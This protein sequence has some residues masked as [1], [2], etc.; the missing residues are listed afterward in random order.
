M[1]LIWAPFATPEA[2]IPAQLLFGK[3][4][5]IWTTQQEPLIAALP[6]NQGPGINSSQ[7]QDVDNEERRATARQIYGSIHLQS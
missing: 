6:T 2:K 3:K 1:S 4:W 5:D 7:S